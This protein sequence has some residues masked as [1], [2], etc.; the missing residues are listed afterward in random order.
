[1]QTTQ[2]DVLIIGGGLTSLT[3]AY[4]L[5]Q[6]DIDF[7]IVEARNRL[8]GRIQTK[9]ND[10][11]APVELGATWLINQQT[12]TLELLNDLNIKVFEQHYGNTAIYHPNGAKTAQL[13]QLPENNSKS[14]RISNGT[15]TLIEALSQK[16][17]DDKIKIN[18]TINSIK[19]ASNGIDAFSKNNTYNCKYI[20]STLPPLLL[21]KTITITPDLPKDIT[22]LLLETHTWMH[23]SI[24]IGLTY[25]TPFW[26][27]EKTSGT[28]YSSAGPIQEFYD[29]SNNKENLY[30]LSGFVNNSYF[31]KSIEERKQ[32]VLEQLVSYYGSIAL[33]YDHYEE[34][35]WNN[36]KFTSIESDGFLMPQ[37]NNGHP[38]FQNSF[39]GNR[40]FIAGAETSRVFPGK[41]EGAITSAKTILTKLKNNLQKH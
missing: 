22:T 5:K 38:L 10:N 9:Y 27:R 39:L 13:V 41:M 1:M 32:L 12:S 21:S 28:I 36:E 17:D 4:L 33:K 11:E 30:A 15:F 25:N 24:R 16:L 2:T 40:F 3:L 20:V 6:N 29:H 8:G 35:L 31:N 37:T 23:D 34:C 18:E 14:Y 7:T 26:K 19:L